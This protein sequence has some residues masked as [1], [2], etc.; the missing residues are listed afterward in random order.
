MR[1]KE[2]IPEERMQQ[3][4]DGALTCGGALRREMQRGDRVKRDL[5]GKGGQFCGKMN[6]KR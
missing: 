6:E 3:R 4:E 1:G 2:T 5:G